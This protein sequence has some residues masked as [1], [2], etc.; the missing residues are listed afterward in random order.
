MNW[1]PA[2]AVPAVAAAALLALTACKQDT[3][4]APGAVTSPQAAAASPKAATASSPHAGA[5]AATRTKTARPAKTPTSDPGDGDGLSGDAGDP[6]APACATAN[7]KI[8]IDEAEGAAGHSI[9][10]VHF[11]NTGPRCWIEGYPTVVTGAGATAGKTPSGYGGGLSDGSEPSPYL[12]EKGDTASA[13]I[14]ALNANADGTACTA[15]T[16]LRVSPP[17]QSSSVK[18]GWSGGC[19]EF[20]VHPVVRGTT[21]QDG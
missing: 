11:R 12:L 17:K 10:P 15:V 1:R 6:D 7:L 14:E 19:A 9:A 13:V 16:T 3:V 18:L 2:L 5:P 21:G 8:T 20:Q 4:A